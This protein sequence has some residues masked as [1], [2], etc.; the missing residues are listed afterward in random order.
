MNHDVNYDFFI[1][2]N[3]H[4]RIEI[5]VVEHYIHRSKSKPETDFIFEFILFFVL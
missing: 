5:D 4:I 1:S 2:G 3:D